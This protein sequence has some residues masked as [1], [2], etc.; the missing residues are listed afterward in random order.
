MKLSTYS[1]RF[2]APHPAPADSTVAPEVAD[3]S[4][5]G[6]MD[7]PHFFPMVAQQY[8][9]ASPS[10][11][12]SDD[13]NDSSIGALADN[14]ISPRK[15]PMGT[16]YQPMEPEVNE[17]STYK[18]DLSGLATMHC[19]SPLSD[20]A[21]YTPSRR[22]K[23]QYPPMEPEIAMEKAAP[24]PEAPKTPVRRSP[25]GGSY[26][27]PRRRVSKGKRL[28]VIH[29]A[30]GSDSGG[31]EQNSRSRVKRHLV[32]RVPGLS[33]YEFLRLRAEKRIKAWRYD[34]P[35]KGKATTA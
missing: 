23:T 35:Q 18:P 1:Y 34:S 31:E 32:K 16:A 8:L 29:E 27:T 33:K 3:N 19:K 10:T 5:M 30:I 6:E 14:T 11:T 28:S 7:E 13:D 25:G 24:E 17:A 15:V 12:S 9:S 4:D 20:L 22:W 2:T 21:P 26:T